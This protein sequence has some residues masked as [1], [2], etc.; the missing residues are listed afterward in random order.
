VSSENRS[1]GG[2]IPL[3]A[4]GDAAAF[5]LCRRRLEYAVDASC[6]PAQPWA[7]RVAAAIRAAC[8]FA[9][10]DPVAAR[11]LTVHAA[12]RRIEGAA[13]FTAMVD[14]YAELFNGDAP[15]IARPQRT[16]RNIVT[17]IARQTLLHLEARPS[18]PLS[19]I[20]P[21]LIVFTLTPYTGLAEAQRQAA[22]R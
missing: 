11:V 8:G 21:D 14:H 2:E 5:E 4:V 18:A 19:E 16:A 7:S 15:A 6:D 22:G 12:F 10:T 9:E 1:G 13:A 3:E 20:A 17:R